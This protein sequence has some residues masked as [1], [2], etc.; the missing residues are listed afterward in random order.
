MLL[1]LRLNQEQTRTEACPGEDQPSDPM[2]LVAVWPPWATGPWPDSSGLSPS[3]EKLI[4]WGRVS[5]RGFQQL[6]TLSF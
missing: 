2:L 5:H 3:L 1:L 6:A 4:N